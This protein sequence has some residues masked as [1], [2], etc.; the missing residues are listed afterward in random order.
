MNSDASA[1]MDRADEPIAVDYVS[2]ESPPFPDAGEEDARQAPEWATDET[3]VST[4][5]DT[6]DQGRREA[7]I[8]LSD[9]TRLHLI[10]Q[11]LVDWKSGTGVDIVLRG[12]LNRRTTAGRLPTGN[13]YT[14]RLA[15]TLTYTTRKIG[16]TNPPI[17]L[18]PMSNGTSGFFLLSGNLRYGQFQSEWYAARNNSLTLH[19]S[20]SWM[21]RARG[22]PRD[23]PID[24]IGT[25]LWT[26]LSNGNRATS[27]YAAK[28][29][30]A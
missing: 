15:H 21:L 29:G 7:V 8:P 2:F 17:D 1:G 9:G 11:I 19:Y 5:F 27:T 23:N 10:Q 24:R 22:E 20:G 3:P 16:R 18:T 25:Q 28:R 6:D 12:W 30:G 14:L 26:A 4:A 13:P